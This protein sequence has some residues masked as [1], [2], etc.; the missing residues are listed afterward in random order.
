MG[1]EQKLHEHIIAPVFLDLL[2]DIAPCNPEAAHLHIL[3]T[4]DQMK[5]E[6]LTDLSKQILDPESS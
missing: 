4:V 6:K 3:R 2:Y 5:Q 1:E